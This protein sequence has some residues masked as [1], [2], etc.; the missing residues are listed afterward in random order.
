MLSKVSSKFGLAVVLALALAVVASVSCAVIAGG[1]AS[2]P[3]NP[4]DWRYDALRELG[5]S[6][7]LELDDATLYT[8]GNPV[9][10]EQ[11]TSSVERTV[12]RIGGPGVTRVIQVM[13][14][15]GDGGQGPLRLDDNP[16][17]V[18]SV[19][20]RQA[21]LLAGLV[22]EFGQSFG[23]PVSVRLDL[24]T[25]ALA[26]G[27]P[28][29]VLSLV[30]SEPAQNG[31]AQQ[32]VTAAASASTPLP[33]AAGVGDIER[34]LTQLSSGVKPPAP[35]PDP[36]FELGLPAPIGNVAVA[37]SSQ[38]ARRPAKPD[39]PEETATPTKTESSGFDLST[40][41]H[42]ADI[43]KVSAAFFTDEAVSNRETSAA[44]GVR[45]GDRD[46]AGFAVGTR[47]T[48]AASEP[49][50]AVKETV[51]SVD[52]KYSLPDI[53]G[54]VVA[55]DSLT[56][57]AGY[58][59]YERGASSAASRDSLQTTASLVIDY[60][61]LLGDAAFLQAGYRYERMRDLIASGAVWTKSDAY[62]GGGLGGWP[63]DEPLRL[64]GADATRTVTSIDFGY[65][66]MGDT[67]LLLG[68]K[69]I[70]FSEVG[71]S[72]TPKNLATAE[73]T[74]RF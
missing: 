18:L 71:S 32:P 22:Q 29:L 35:L 66:L 33:G 14:Q 44:V 46:E 62:D 73:V 36:Q 9:S 26:N 7:L 2:A 49:G 3:V 48:E 8:G 16:G 31:S 40:N 23:T 70:D 20:P 63:S 6:G 12:L 11:M 53:T 1:A 51:T 57:R 27:G 56:V 64:S 65:K 4:G 21:A 55:G 68:Y 34:I 13:T 52:V 39:P 74:I 19:S 58:E 43:L 24:S 42:L 25:A 61:L 50:K 60:K 15:D 54:N 30:P 5:L 72:E 45:V 10:I 69:L 41:V 28:A 17:G 59:L 47:V 37:L 38:A 67:A